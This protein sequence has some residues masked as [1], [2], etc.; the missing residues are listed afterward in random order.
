MKYPKE[1]KYKQEKVFK[2][3]AE[4]FFILILEVTYLT[5]AI[6]IGHIAQPWYMVGGAT[7]VGEHQEGG[8]IRGWPTQGANCE[9]SKVQ[10]DLSL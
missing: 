3:E 1:R 7:Q 2:M 10:G 4:G 8:I 5:S 6:S 9:F